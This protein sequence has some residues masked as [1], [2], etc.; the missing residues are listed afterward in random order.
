MCPS[1]GSG[2]CLYRRDISNTHKINFISKSVITSDQIT[3]T[4]I[5]HSRAQKNHTRTQ[6]GQ[7]IRK[8]KYNDTFIILGT[9]QSLTRVYGMKGKGEGYPLHCIDCKSMRE[10]MNDVGKYTFLSALHVWM[11][12]S[13][14]ENH[15]SA[16]KQKLYRGREGPAKQN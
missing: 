16:V 10:E 3:V 7:K 9:G 6:L 5:G 2:E 12:S 13:L 8:S 14:Q 4:E 11:E 15:G 1:S